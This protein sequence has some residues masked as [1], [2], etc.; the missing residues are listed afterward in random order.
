[1]R[2]PSPG[3]V[4]AI[5]DAFRWK[6]CRT[7]T[8]P[9]TGDAPPCPTARP[10][11]RSGFLTVLHDAAGFT[12]GFL[13]TNA[14]GRPLEF[15]LTTPVQPNR[16][17]QILYGSTLADYIH[18]DLIGKTL[19]EKTSAVPTLIVTDTL[20]ALPLRSRVGIPVV[21]VGRHDSEFVFEHE[22]STLPLTLLAI[23]AG[24]RE[25]IEAMLNELDSGVDLAEPFARIR[26]ALSETRSTG[27][28]SRAA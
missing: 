8:I 21:A 5:A 7:T 13:V 9:S 27:A 26:E 6:G 4:K 12:G 15:R 18:A 19:V 2:A 20:E 23:H 22:R 16:V 1:M 17:Q 24:D 11:F 10:G 3:R 25:T 14:W 28:A